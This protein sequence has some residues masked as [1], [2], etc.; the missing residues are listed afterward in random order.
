[1]QN[2]MTQTIRIFLLIEAASFIAASLVHAGALITGYEHQK[3]RIAESVLASA[4]LAGAALTWVRPAW[5]RMAGLAA[6]GF[7]LLGT[8]VGIFTIVIGIGPRTVLDIVYHIV[9]VVV[10]VSGLVVAMRAGFDHA[11]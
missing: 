10:L 7:A 2:R 8:M 5:T 9:I 4:L 3:A 1:M 6:Q 11:G